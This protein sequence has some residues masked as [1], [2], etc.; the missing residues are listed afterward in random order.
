MKTIRTPTR[1]VPIVLKKPI[2]TPQPIP[3][4]PNF[5]ELGQAVVLSDLA[6]HEGMTI[7]GVCQFPDKLKASRLPDNPSPHLRRMAHKLNRDSIDAVLW[8]CSYSFATKP[9]RPT[10]QHTMRQANAIE[11]GV[12]TDQEAETTEAG[13]DLI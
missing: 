10:A 8:R 12:G 9:A 6:N 7:E 2:V 5:T 11:S 4:T 1:V 3:D 13:S